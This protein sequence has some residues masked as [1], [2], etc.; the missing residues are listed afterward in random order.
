MDIRPNLIKKALE[1]I[2]YDIENGE[3]ESVESL[4]DCIKTEDLLEYLDVTENEFEFISME[5]SND[6]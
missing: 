4:L 3:A 6:Y 2:L 5:F 1:I